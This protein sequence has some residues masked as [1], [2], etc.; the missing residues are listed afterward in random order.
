MKAQIIKDG[1]FHVQKMFISMKLENGG[2][3]MTNTEQNDVI[4]H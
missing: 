1:S 2:N 4:Y 3:K